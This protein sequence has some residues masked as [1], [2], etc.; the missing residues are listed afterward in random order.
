HVLDAATGMNYM[1]QRYYDPAIGRFLSVDPV[2]AYEKPGANFNRYW[3][4]NNNPYRFI[5]PDGRMN[6]DTKDQEMMRKDPRSMGAHP[7]I[8]GSVQIVGSMS[9]ISSSSSN[10]GGAS[11]GTKATAS[12]RSELKNPLS[13]GGGCSMTATMGSCGAAPPDYIHV[14][15]GI[16]VASGGAMLT[17]NGT[18]L[19]GGGVAHATPKSMVSGEVGWAASVGYLTARGTAAD[20]DNFARGATTGV[21]GYF[22]LGG[23]YVY[24][25]S[26]SAIEVGYGG[27]GF[28]LQA[29]EYMKPIYSAN[30]D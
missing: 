9:T 1:Q 4:A 14:S 28:S 16:Y 11:Q 6:Q 7:G 20:V 27:G 18:L 29:V 8:A 24:N 19:A 26:G 23:S 12:N 25:A 13:F 21:G 10:K 30:S 5:D 17:R 3:Y 2:T 15:A 22:G